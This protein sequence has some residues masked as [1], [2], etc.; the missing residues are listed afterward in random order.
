MNTLIIAEAGVNHN[1]DL[2]TALS[3]VDFAKNSGADIVKFQTFIAKNLVTNN[4][5]K[6]NYQIASNSHETQ[7]QMLEQLQM[8]ESMHIELLNYCKAMKIDFL[9]TA[10][11]L[12]SIDFLQSIGQSLFKIPSGEIT[13]LPYLRHVA[14]VAHEVILSTGA[15]NLDEIECALEILY[16]N[17]QTN[18]SITVLHCTTAYPAPM[19][20]VNLMAM[21]KIANTF[22]VKVGYSD[23]TLGI[24]VPI[25]AVALGATTIE[26]HFTLDRKM[27]GPDH[28]A[29]LEPD[30][31][32]LMVNSIRNIEK[33]TGSGVKTPMQSELENIEI[34]R[35]SIVAKNSIL[36]GEIFTFDNLTTKRPATGLSPML[37]DSVIGKVA[38]R[39]YST[40]EK[41]N[42]E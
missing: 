34:I 27:S 24:E 29:S 20:D 7:I 28:K 18:E 38:T 8:S 11:D 12:E 41:I 2:K 3:M 17:G 14:K 15:S 21:Q 23:H 1:G 26:K 39:N 19:I 31:L 37:W 9:S 42:L 4:A 13:N 30:E 16:K 25:A 22:N 32:E 33:A 36:K 6:A 35:K 40:D 5:P 10:F